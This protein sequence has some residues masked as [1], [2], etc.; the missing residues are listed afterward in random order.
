MSLTVIDGIG[1]RMNDISFRVEEH[2]IFEIR[3]DGSKLNCVRK[4][5]VEDDLAT[6]IDR[7]SNCRQIPV[8]AKSW[9]CFE[10][11]TCQ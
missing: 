2:N 4:L 3:M 1:Q 10:A 8:H 9:P 11:V 6:S 5:Y 7:R